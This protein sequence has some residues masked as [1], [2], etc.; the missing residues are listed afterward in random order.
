MEPTAVVELMV[1]D[2]RPSQFH[3]AFASLDVVDLKELFSNRGAVM[4]SVPSFLRGAFRTTMRVVLTE[5][6]K[7]IDEQSNVRMTRGWKLFLLLPRLLLH[8]PVRGGFVPKKI[9]EARFHMFQMG[10]W[11][12]LLDASISNT[13]RIHQRSVRRR[14]WE[15]GAGIEKKAN[16]ALSFWFRW[17]SCQ[18]HCKHSTELPLLQ[19]RW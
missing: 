5:L 1:F 19:E 13:A 12:E 10:Q 9:L 14:R 8:K 18:P 11:H 3:A 15:Q 17:K 7:E 6:V 2:S 16:R 4:R